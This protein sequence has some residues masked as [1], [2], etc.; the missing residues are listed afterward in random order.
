MPQL[1]CWRAWQIRPSSTVQSPLRFR[2]SSG[3][4]HTLTLPCGPP[5][6]ICSVCSLLTIPAIIDIIHD[7]KKNKGIR[8]TAV[9]VLM[10]AAANPNL[11]SAI[12]TQIPRL[13][14][15]VRDDNSSPRVSTEIIC[16]IASY[17]RHLTS[18]LATRALTLRRSIPD[19]HTC[20]NSRYH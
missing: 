2:D 17:S 10:R 19:G 4:S 6:D 5:S 16:N 18:H 20:G 8:Q 1:L 14:W 12:V 11:H 3:T 7:K 13:F 9:D 15:M